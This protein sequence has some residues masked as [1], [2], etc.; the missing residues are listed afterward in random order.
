MNK[1]ICRSGVI[2]STLA[3]YYRGVTSFQHRSK[4]PLTS[5]YASGFN[6][7]PVPFF[8]RKATARGDGEDT[9]KEDPI[10]ESCNY[11]DLKPMDIQVQEEDLLGYAIDSF[12]RGDYNLQ[13]ADDAPAPHPGLSPGLT[14]ETSLRSLRQ[15]DSPGPS[16]GAAVLMRF[17]VP[18]SRGE[19]WGDSTRAGKDPWKEILRGALTP[20]ML[21]RRIRAS[22]FSGL[23]DWTSLDVTEG[24]YSLE[25]DLV[26]LP[27]IS[28]VNVALFFGE[29]IEPSLIQF[30]LRRMGGVWLIDTARHS[31]K[32][33]FIKKNE[34]E[35]SQS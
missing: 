28:F 11:N 4:R 6:P 18:L 7:A 13:F 10:T 25:K 23:L 21:A 12:L 14:T 24:A 27:S 35:T 3:V 19:R 8:A 33:L 30:T 2:L 5:R 1:K 34:G 32:G 16:H 20:R 22:E 9:D 26:G 17:C 29:G 31:R 15:L